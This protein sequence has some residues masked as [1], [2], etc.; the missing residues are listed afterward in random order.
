[1]YVC[2]WMSTYCTYIRIA[3]YIVTLL[4]LLYAR[5]FVYNLLVRYY[6]LPE[7]SLKTKSKRT[8][9]YEG[10]N[11]HSLMPYAYVRTYVHENRF[12]F[13]FLQHKF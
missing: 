5:I 3:T 1:M 8:L 13:S 11:S 10:K 4:L 7:N 6:I 12:C 9:N 2:T